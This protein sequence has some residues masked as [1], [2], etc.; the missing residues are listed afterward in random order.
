ML[1]NSPTHERR[2]QPSGLNFDFCNDLSE[3]VLGLLS[4]KH[5]ERAYEPSRCDAEASRLERW[6]NDGNEV[7]ANRE[8]RREIR[9][10]VLI[11]FLTLPR[12]YIDEIWSQIR[13]MVAR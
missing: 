6:E 13:R 10:L 1:V 5:L 4:P 12:F 9:K 2:A 7:A 3:Q 8:Y 11:T